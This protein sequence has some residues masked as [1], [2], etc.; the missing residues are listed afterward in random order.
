MELLKNDIEKLKYLAEHASSKSKKREYVIVLETLLALKDEIENT[1]TEY[2]PSNISQYFIDKSH[3]NNQKQLVNKYS[4]KE[5]KDFINMICKNCQS[6]TKLYYEE[7]YCKNYI[8]FKD[9][10]DII[11]D[12]FNTFD[13]KLY[14]LVKEMLTNDHLL[15]VNDHLTSGEGYSI[16]NPFSNNCYIF[17]VID[18]KFKLDNISC[19]VHELGHIISFQNFKS[20]PNAYKQSISNSF[21]EVPA[22]SFEFLF[23]DFL[24]K[25]NLY[26]KEVEKVINNNL[27]TLNNYISFLKVINKV[28]DQLDILRYYETEE[29]QDILNSVGIVKSDDFV[30]LCFSDLTSNHIY[31]L[32]NLISL[33]YLSKYRLDEEKTKRNIMSFISNIGIYDDFDTMNKFGLNLEELKRCEYVKQEVNRNQKQL[34]KNTQI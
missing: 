9:V 7:L 1:K 26:T 5:Y 6:N 28:I 21:I 24:L 8:K 33:N 11:L 19:L 29:I 14:P 10:K 22:F 31:T 15:I 30:D 18:N 2:S 25:N 3:L 34:R 13:N 17:T 32:G 12:F 16:L 4:Q 27:Y 20:N 23:L